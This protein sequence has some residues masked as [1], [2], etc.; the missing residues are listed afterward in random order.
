MIV[1]F[2]TILTC[3]VYLLANSFSYKI[4]SQRLDQPPLYDVLHEILPDLS[5]NVYIRD[6]ILILMIL[7]IIFLPKLWEYIPE[8][9]NSFM[10]IVLI[11][12]IC[13]FFTNIPSSH[14][15]SKNPSLYDLNNSYHNAVSGHAALFMILALLYIKG[16][17]NVWIIWISVF[18]YSL[19]IIIS[20]AHYSICVIQG[21]LFTFLI[22]N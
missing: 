22:A 11:K 16:G 7:P 6:I 4:G 14:F 10:I 3:V 17:F 18:L 12:A 2:I 13:I 19:L 1:I 9:W 20:R 8:L 5:K 15:S 21:L